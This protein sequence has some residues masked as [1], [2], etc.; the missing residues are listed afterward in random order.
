MSPPPW[1]TSP[2][3]MSSTSSG[4]TPLRSSA[5]CTAYL[6]RS[7]ALT[8][9]SVPLR[10]V[11]IGVRQAEKIT[12]SGIAYSL[13]R[14]RRSRGAARLLPS[15]GGAAGCGGGR[16]AS[17]DRF[18]HSEQREQA[19]VDLALERDV[20]GIGARGD[21]SLLHDPVVALPV[22][23]ARG[24]GPRPDRVEREFAAPQRALVESVGAR[25]G[26]RV[27]HRRER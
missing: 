12:A 5:S 14:S 10:A 19:D 9:T 4:V 17:R 26:R 8:S 1:S 22:E 23:L 16:D 27:G 24:E 3:T 7:N 18:G 20:H 15:S 25:S 13:C 2:S 11:P 21:I 6:A